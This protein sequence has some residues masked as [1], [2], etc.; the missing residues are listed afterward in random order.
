MTK[1]KFT[2]E[3]N[4]FYLVSDLNEKM[5]NIFKKFCKKQS[6]DINLLSFSYQKEKINGELTLE[7]FLKSKEKRKINIFVSKVEKNKNNKNIISVNNQRIL[8][9]LCTESILIMIKN[10]KITLYNCKNGHKVTNILL[11]EY[12]EIQH[13]TQSDIV[14]NKCQKKNL[15]QNLFYRC[16]SCKMNLCINCCEKHNKSHNIIDYEDKFQKCENHNMHYLSVCRDCKLNLCIKCINNHAQHEIFSLKKYI[17]NKQNLLNGLEE[18]KNIIY[19]FIEDIQDLKKTFDNPKLNMII[20]NFKVYYDIYN[21]ILNDYINIYDKNYE[22]LE[23]AKKLNNNNEI[24]KDII[25]INNEINI[26]NKY[27]N[28]LKIFDK[29]TNKIDDEIE[30]TYKLD[31]K[32]INL[33]GK[34]FVE[35]NKRICRLFIEGQKYQLQESIYYENKNKETLTIILKGFNHVTDISYM[36]VECSSLINISKMNTS[37]ITKMSYLFNKCFLLKEL[38]DISKWQTNKVINMKGIFNECTSL[39]SL[40]DISKWDTSKVSDM[41]SMFN[42]C[43]S[44]ISM[45]D[46]S[47]WDTSKVTSMSSMFNKC[48]SLISIPNI[49]KWNTSEVVYMDNL[50]CECKLISSIPDISKWNINKVINMDNMFKMCIS[51]S[52][53]PDISKMNIENVINKKNIFSNCIS[54]SFLP[55]VDFN[56]N[57]FNKYDEYI[58]CININEFKDNNFGFMNMTGTNNILGINNMMELGMNNMNMMG[59]NNMNMMGMN[60]MNMMGMNYMDMMGMNYMNMMGMNNMNM[61]GMNNMNMMGMN[62]MNMMGMYNMNMMGMN[63]MMMNGV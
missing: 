9:P 56:E 5:E 32:S 30:I 10:Y 46:I 48:S 54:L 50:F 18:K 14:C 63:N 12:K 38:P 55:D 59:M 39:I 23:N 29:M 35:N 17:I 34:N 45:P 61:M 47:K 3:G 21:N 62:N 24:I 11:D 42:E 49:S 41:S 40:P 8:C 37:N 44:L 43:L 36:F 19:K 7:Q 51:L 52:T 13:L 33:F 57:S 2:F 53:L 58:N 1:I 16:L 60:N 26:T 25:L 20:D 6:I 15:I 27:N 28:L 22:I 4:E 31:K